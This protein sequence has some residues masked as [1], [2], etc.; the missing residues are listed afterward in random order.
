MPL[1]SFALLGVDWYDFGPDLNP[2]PRLASAV[3]GAIIAMSRVKA[4]IS[5]IIFFKV[6]VFFM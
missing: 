2:P 1:L 3:D 6:N 5:I 4:I